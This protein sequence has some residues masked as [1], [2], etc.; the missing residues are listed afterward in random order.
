MRPTIRCLVIMVISFTP[1]GIASQDVLEEE[2]LY[3]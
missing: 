2:V 1:V 3:V